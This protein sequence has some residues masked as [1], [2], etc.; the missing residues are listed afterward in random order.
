MIDEEIR[1]AIRSSTEEL[2][3]PEALARR[4]EGWFQQ[5]VEGNESL[6]DSDSVRRH[7]ELLMEAV[8]APEIE[9]DGE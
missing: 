8:E 1:R 6:S 2:G 4:L 7:L 5:L 3:Q 9:G